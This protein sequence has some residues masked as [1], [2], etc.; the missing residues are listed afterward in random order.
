MYK[1]DHVFEED[2]RLD[3]EFLHGII[4]SD[5]PSIWIEM[6][7]SPR[8]RGAQFVLVLNEYRI[9]FELASGKD[10]VRMQSQNESFQRRNWVIGKLFIDVKKVDYKNRKST[11]T[12]NKFF[13]SNREEQDYVVNIIQLALKHYDERFFLTDEGKRYVDNF[14]DANVS[15]CEELENRLKSDEFLKFDQ[16]RQFQ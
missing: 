14:D 10:K 8:D 2:P 4:V 6:W 11:G 1:P 5:D 16:Y 15:F 7:G 12:C 3:C 13:F 9:G